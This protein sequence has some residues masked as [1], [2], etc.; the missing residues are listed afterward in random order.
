[1]MQAGPLRSTAHA[2]PRSGRLGAAAIALGLALLGSGARGGE[3]MASFFGGMGGTRAGLRLAPDV[4]FYSE[5]NVVGQAAA[6]DLARYDLS[7][8]MPLGR[9]ES[10]SWSLTVRASLL[11][12]DTVAV[13]PSTGAAVPDELWKVN[14]GLAYG[15]RY[16]DGRFLGVRA[17]VGSASDEPFDSG[18]E[19]AFSTVIFYR[20]PAAGKN[21][22]FYFLALGNNREEL[23]YVPIPGFAYWSQPS[24]KFQALIGLPFL[25]LNYRPSPRW[26][27]GF[28]YFAV[29]NV[30]ASATFRPH[31]R[32]GIYA[33]YDWR[34]DS[35][36]RAGR[37]SDD[38]K[39]FNYEMRVALG[40]KVDL[41]RRLSVDVSAGWSFDRFMF[42]SEDYFD[43]A[44]RLDLEDAFCVRVK[45]AVA[46][47]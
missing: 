21:A 23:D 38:E 28:S 35:F 24:E 25:A 5:E 42:E 3:D 30:R 8:T 11:D 2:L 1:M 29:T 15:R 27:L 32:V 12:V 7:A 34:H 47:W 45:L 19:T 39:L 20:K 31:R 4:T 22:W 46:A 17:S 18:D 26:A 16:D 33:S 10:D 44:Q 37:T 41:P 13:F 9:S 6:L 14:L 36:F 40:V 43:R